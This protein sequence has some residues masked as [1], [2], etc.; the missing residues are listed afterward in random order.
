MKHY[1]CHWLIFTH[2]LRDKVTHRHFHTLCMVYVRLGWRIAPTEKD[3]FLWWIG[4]VWFLGKEWKY[5]IHFCRYKENKWSIT[6]AIDSSL[7][8]HWETKSL[9]ANF[10]HYVSQMR[11]F[12]EGLPRQKKIVF[13]DELLS[14]L[15]IRDYI[16]LNAPKRMREYV[17][18]TWVNF[19]SI[20]H[21]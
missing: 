16:S 5:Y 21:K 13:S 14:S 20:V 4:I 7:H 8:T 12:A 17:W 1:G 3:C 6:A 15:M 19:N 18:L 9:I 11:D 2:S 10:I